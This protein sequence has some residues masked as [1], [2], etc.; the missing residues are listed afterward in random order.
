MPKNNEVE[1]ESPLITAVS[2]VDGSLV[3][4]EG[5]ASEP[6]AT[7]SR[8]GSTWTVALEADRHKTSEVAGSFDGATGGELHQYAPSGGGG[9]PD[10]LNFYFA[11]NVAFQIQGKTVTTR[12]YLAQG[13][14]ALT[15][16]WWI[17]GSSVVNDGEPDL[18][19]VANDQVVAVLRI[20]GDH[21]SFVFTPV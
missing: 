3:I 4:S 6:P 13:S 5:E 1:L 15:N 12:L 20:S 9:T 18:V 7:I 19:L 16:N 10:E 21:D 14:Y 11:V 17:G 8:D 2:Y